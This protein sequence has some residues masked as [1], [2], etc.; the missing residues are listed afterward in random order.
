[1]NGTT[2]SRDL[3]LWVRHCSI[4]RL[5]FVPPFSELD[6][7]N[8]AT[9]MTGLL[10]LAFRPLPANWSCRGATTTLCADT[11]D[12]GSDRRRV[13]RRFSQVWWTDA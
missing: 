6:E 13:R 2:G 12:F 10:S 11:E 4:K 7:D 8:E 3:L 5:Q 9:T 1:M